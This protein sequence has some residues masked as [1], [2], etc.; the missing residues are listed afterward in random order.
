MPVVV[1]DASVLLK[2]VLHEGEAHVAQA[3]ALQLAIGQGEVRAVVP[4]LWYFEVGN[5]IGRR[6]PELA[7]R[8][9]SGLRALEMEEITFDAALEAR[10]LQL[11]TECGVTFYDACYHALAIELDGL[12]VTSDAR[13]LE[14]A[15]AVG[16]IQ[17]LMDWPLGSS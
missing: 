6:I 14:R 15:R 8:A 5:T 10:T 16:H 13:Y 1:P 17:H 2:W 3:L 12:F 11:M 9:L 7:A 4:P